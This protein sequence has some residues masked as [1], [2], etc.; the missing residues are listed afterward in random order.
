M[1]KES[2]HTKPPLHGIAEGMAEQLY[3]ATLEREPDNFDALYRLSLLFARGGKLAAAVNLLLRAIELKPAVADAHFSLGNFFQALYRHEEALESYDRALAIRPESPEVL[4]NRGVVL[5]VL[6]RHVAAISSFNQALRFRAHYVDALANRGA[7]LQMSGRYLQAISTFDE[8]LTLD[9]ERKYILGWAFHSRSFICDWRERDSIERLIT[10]GVRA[11]K[12]VSPP[13]PYLAMS[14]NPADQ[15]A[16]AGSFVQDRFPPARLPLWQGERYRHDRIRI[17]YLSADFRDHAV[18]FLTAGLFER[19]DQSKFESIAISFGPDTGSAL[20]PRLMTAFEQFIDVRSKSEEKVALLLRESEVD[21]AVDLMGFTTGSRT[22][23][24]ARRPAPIQINYLGYP[25]TMGAEYIDY[26]IADEHVI[27]RNQQMHYSEKVVY[28]P[29]CYQVNDS[30][31][32]IAQHMPTRT[33]VGLP[34]QG[35]VFCC[36]NNSYK[37]TPQIFD[38]WMRLLKA[39]EG[40]VLWLVRSSATT[41]RNLRREARARGVTP[42]RLIFAARIKPPDYLARYR[43]ADLFLDTLPFNAGAT[44][45]DALWA[46]LPVVTCAG[47][48]FAAR[49]AGSLLRA[50][51]LPELVTD[52]LDEYEALALKLAA[53]PAWLGEIKE[54]LARNRLT[55]PLFDTDRFRRHIE[56]AYRTMWET[57][58]RGEAPRSFTVQPVDT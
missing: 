25:G 35:F 16:C 54:K 6:G 23:I 31:R 36:F 7:T 33:G 29:E 42:D 13:L 57:Y 22:G 14:M 47:Q 4:N 55:M 53:D 40:S 50:I 34:D 15:L 38:V 45:S 24:F 46:G 56:S 48:P 32:V 19:H 20:R 9:A 8:V 2:S 3:L 10:E 17:A 26:I 52:T 12:L 28:L 49:M 11:R 5:Q 43:L 41:V 37:L 39:M 51:G 18:A 21:I 1:E 27:P 30:K 58:Q 44:A